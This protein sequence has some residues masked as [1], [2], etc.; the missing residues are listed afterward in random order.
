MFCFWRRIFAQSEVF[1]SDGG[2][3]DAE[4]SG[5][6]PRISNASAANRPPTP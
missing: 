6:R 1:A 5:S 2:L 4:H 3:G